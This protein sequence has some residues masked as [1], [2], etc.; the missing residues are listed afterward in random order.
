MEEA[1]KAGKIRFAAFSSHSIP[2]A[3]RVMREGKFAAVQLPFN[4][5]D[6]T[7]ADEAIPL[8]KELDIGFISM[9]PLGGGLLSDAKLAFKY[10]LQYDSIVPDPGIEKLSEMVEIV[11][12]VNANETLNTADNEAIESIRKEMGSV[13]CHRCEYCMPCPQSIGISAVL[14]VESFTKRFPRDAVMRMAGK[15]FENALNCDECRSCVSKCPY[16][17]DIPKLI[18]EKLVIWDKFKA[19]S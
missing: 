8:A 17:L 3:L 2:M 15:S 14:N 9:K 7:A 1:V 11:S 16:D 19:L 12:I 4:F 18:K 5:V 13:W 10:L 6:V